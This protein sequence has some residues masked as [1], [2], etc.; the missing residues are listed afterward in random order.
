MK[1]LSLSVLAF[2]LFLTGCE[3]PSVNRVQ[4]TVS[5]TA[6]ATNAGS[7]TAEANSN[8][9]S[10]AP[11]KGDVLAVTPE[12][13]KI[14][15][16]GSKVTGK[17]DGGFR[18][19][20]G[21]I[22]LVNAKAEE[23]AVSV[24]IDTTSIYSDNADLTEHLKSADFFDVEK[25]PK[26]SFRSSKIVADPAKGADVYNVT[27]DLTLHGVTKSVSFPATI[28]VND[29]DVTVNADFSINR[30]DFEI[31]YAGMANDLIRD[32]VVMKLELKTPR[33]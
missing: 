28:K 31:N 12:S 17:H 10:V 18:Q 26:G 30:K 3:D 2:S 25:F 29:A 1:V 22:D 23:S 24:E 33:K 4:A 8:T 14:E 27:G 9:R 16:I 32:G 7:T 19:F 13:S 15:W 21:T 5:N 6:V 20:T 11:A